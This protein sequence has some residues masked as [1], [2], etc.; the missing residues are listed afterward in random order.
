M[1]VVISEAKAMHSYEVPDITVIEILEGHP[2]YLKWI[3][4]ETRS[5]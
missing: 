1:Q 4:E 2:S 3:K 5:D